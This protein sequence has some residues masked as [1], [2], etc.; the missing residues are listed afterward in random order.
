MRST[1]GATHF[2]VSMRK[3]LMVLVLAAAAL[4]LAA[5]RAEV[6]MALTVEE[7]GSGVVVVEFGFD[8]EFRELMS[9]TGGD[10]DDLFG[11]LE[12]DFPEG[13]VTTRE[14]GD[15]TFQGVEVAFDDINEITDEFAGTSADLI[16]GFGD[17]FSF[18]LDDTSAVFDATLSGQ[19]LDLGG[20]VPF[21]VS[22]FTGGDFFSASFILAM[23]GTVTAHNADEILP[24]GRLRW[25]L[26]ILGG[27]LEMHAESEFGGGGVPWLWLILGIVLVIGVGAMIAAVVLGRRQEREAVSAAAAA[28]PQ[29]VAPSRDDELPTDD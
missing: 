25:D 28:Y 7:D 21:D 3:S 2:E 24:D 27:T 26:P 6:N 9:S 14:E 12:S 18:V 8:E 1:I 19:E 20:E 16:G 23:P 17:S 10:P 5:C 4:V 29:Q 22:E 11:D 15:M 13:E